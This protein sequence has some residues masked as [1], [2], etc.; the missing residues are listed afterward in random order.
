MMIHD[1][2]TG[3]DVRAPAEIEAALSKRHGAG[4]NSFWLGHVAGGF[5][6]INIVVKGDLAHVHYFAK[7][8]HP[9]FASVAELPAI[10]PYDT[11]VFFISPGEKIWVLND[12][13]VPFSQALRAAHEFASSTA[14]PKCIRWRSLVLG[15]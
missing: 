13:I 2:E 11:S 9:G 6:A 4:I 15:E 8:D 7:E 5:P 12:E 14:M 10:R 3:V 1:F